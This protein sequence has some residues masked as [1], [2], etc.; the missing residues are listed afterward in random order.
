MSSRT[1][2][3]RRTALCLRACTALLS[4]IKSFPDC[5][6]PFPF[7]GGWLNFMWFWNISLSF[8]TSR[9]V[10]RSRYTPEPHF[11][12]LLGSLK[13]PGAWVFQFSGP[14]RIWGCQPNLSWFNIWLFWSWW[15]IGDPS[16]SCT[17]G[18]T[19][20]GNS[21]YQCSGLLWTLVVVIRIMRHSNSTAAIYVEQAPMPSCFRVQSLCRQDH[22]TLKFAK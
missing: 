1:G 10:A 17:I 5:G 22:Q 18:G 4:S 12:A 21:S 9:T 11:S 3:L 13:V 6:C 7:R 2:Q 19:C 16:R 8:R 20:W 15:C 14:W